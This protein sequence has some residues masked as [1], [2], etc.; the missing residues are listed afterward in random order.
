MGK[1]PESIAAPPVAPQDG[2]GLPRSG[3]RAD[4]SGLHRGAMAGRSLRPSAR[5]T[6]RASSQ[7]GEVR[8]AEREV[9]QNSEPELQPKGRQGGFV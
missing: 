6:L 3:V 4:P 5:R 7:S 2:S 9:V 1:F 8:G